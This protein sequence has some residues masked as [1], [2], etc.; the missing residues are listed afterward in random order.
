MTGTDQSCST[1]TDG[2]RR[3]GY[4]GHSAQGGLRAESCSTAATGPDRPKQAILVGMKMDRATCLDFLRANQPLP[5]DRELTREFADRL[6]DVRI[7]LS[8][9]PIPE[10]LPLLLRVYGEGD[11]LGVY[12]LIEDTLRNYPRRAVVSALGAAL[13]DAP[14][15]TRYWNLQL[16]AT[17]PD[18]SLVDQIGELLPTLDHDSRYA[19]LTALEAI[20]GE[21]VQEIVGEWSSRESSVELRSLIDDILAGS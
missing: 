2:V 5:P 11:G 10:A 3:V 15:P 9:H 14:A 7:W 17:F 18:A 21:R 20:G 19:A 4:S 8:G 12:P 1:A 13:R 6:D 16:S